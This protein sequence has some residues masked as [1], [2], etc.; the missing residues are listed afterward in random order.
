M[1]CRLCG[2]KT[3]GCFG[4]LCEDCF[5]DVAEIT[6]EIAQGVPG[7]AGISCGKSH[8]RED[9]NDWG[10]YGDIAMRVMDQDR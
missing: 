1:L 8:V 3:N 7:I 4:L 10:S 6:P 9:L 5:A 2:K